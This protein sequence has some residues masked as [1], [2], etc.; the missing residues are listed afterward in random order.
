MY[1]CRRN[2]LTSK[3]DVGLLYRVPLKSVAME[4]S[5]GRVMELAASVKNLE[6][7]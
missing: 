1:D 5:G 7:S 6:F 4:I 2:K 3:S